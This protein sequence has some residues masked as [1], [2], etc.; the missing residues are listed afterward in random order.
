LDG[1]GYEDLVL[2][3]PADSTNGTCTGAVHI[4]EGG[5]T[6]IPGS[7][8]FGQADFG[9]YGTSRSDRLGFVNIGDL[10]AS[11][12]S[13]IVISSAAGEGEAYL[14]YGPIK[15]DKSVTDATAHITGFDNAHCFLNSTLADIDQN[16]S[17]D[18][19]ATCPET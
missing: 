1:D 5:S 16:G 4:F 2:G 9:V 6:A 12:L 3:N 18:L 15:A 19:V 8:T 10:D 17:S 11:G 13:D 14:F 7:M